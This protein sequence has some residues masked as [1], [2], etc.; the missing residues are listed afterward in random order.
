MF[1]GGVGS[2]YSAR[3]AVYAHGA[4]T[5]TLLFADTRVEAPDLYEFIQAAAD[6]LG[7]ELVTVADGRTPFE[8]F[9]DDRFLGN[10]RLANC[11]KYL[12]QKPC[13]DWIEANCDPDDTYL[14]VGIDWSEIHRLPAIEAGWDPYCVIAPLTHPP[15][16]TKEHM[17]DTL[18]AEGLAL[19]K[20]YA[21]GFPHNNCMAQGCV[22]GGQAYWRNLLRT[23]RATFLA[24]EAEEEELRV[25]LD[26]PVTIL[27]DRVGGAS[28]PVTLKEFRERIERQGELFDDGEWGGC[29]CFT[30]AA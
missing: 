16:V 3:Q 12:K 20:A 25:Y 18:K 30:E 26:K 19:P 5:V 23:D 11:S 10:S 24:T 4:E 7:C 28:T 1:S 9:K 17:L 21:D 8:V 13:R 6:N 15:Y 29:G 27:R 14:F 22:R 2:W